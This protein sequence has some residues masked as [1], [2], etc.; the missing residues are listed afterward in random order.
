MVGKE[1]IFFVKPYEMVWK[2]A[3]FLTV[4]GQVTAL[5]K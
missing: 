3:N 2:F 1:G 4:T 5:I